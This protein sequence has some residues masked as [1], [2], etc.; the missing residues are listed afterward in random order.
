MDVEF[1][2]EAELGVDLEPMPQPANKPA[3][4]SKGSALINLLNMRFLWVLID[5]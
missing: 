1:W 3:N 5:E 4:A 2:V